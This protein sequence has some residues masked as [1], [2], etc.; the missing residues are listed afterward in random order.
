SRLTLRTESLYLLRGPAYFVLIATL[1]IPI[2]GVAYRVMNGSGFVVSPAKMDPDELPR[3]SNSTSPFSDVKSA[4]WIRE[5]IILTRLSNR[6]ISFSP[7]LDQTT[8]FES[9]AWRL[10]KMYTS[11]FSS[12]VDPRLPVNALRESR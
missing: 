8:N 9:E 5:G 11:P 10:P 7:L 4:A 1:W 2:R 6:S 12:T 3:S